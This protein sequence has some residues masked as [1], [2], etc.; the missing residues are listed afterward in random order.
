HPA[1]AAG[2][3]GAGPRP[4]RGGAG[5]MLTRLLRKTLALPSRWP[6]YLPAV[7]CLRA[8]S[9]AIVMYHGV[10]AEP[11]PAFHWCQLPAPGSAE[12]IEFLAREYRILPVREVVRRLAYGQPLPD[13]AVA[14]TFDDGFR[15]VLTTAFPVLERYQ[16]PAT[17]FL[18]TGLV[19]TNQPAWPDR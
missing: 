9:A 4:Q 5:T 11:L 14:L 17:V 8:R 3:A 6:G 7:R 1:G 10:T 16:A 18:V 13:R 12:Q 15:N 2:Q 19:G